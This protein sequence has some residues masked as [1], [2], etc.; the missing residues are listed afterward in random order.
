[1]SMDWE[2]IAKVVFITIVLSFAI[3]ILINNKAVQYAEKF[4]ESQPD[5]K[6]TT[7]SAKTEEK[8]KDMSLRIKDTYL[9]LFNMPPTKE[10][11]NFYIQFFKGKTNVTD[12]QL[13]ETI[14][15]S[16]PTL[17]KTIYVGNV[18]SDKDIVNGTADEVAL[19]FNEILERNPSPEELQFYSKM[20]KKDP[21]QIEKMKVLLM[22]SKEYEILQ[23]MQSNK[24]N[25]LTLRGVSDR[26]VEFIVKTIYGNVARSSDDVDDETLQ[27]LK[28]KFVELDMDQAVFARFVKSIVS[29]KAAKPND[30]NTT[31]SVAVSGNGTQA[32]VKDKTTTNQSCTQSNSTTR[33]N[34]R[35]TNCLEKEA[36][37]TVPGSNDKPITCAMVKAIQ[38]KAT[39]QF[40]KNY[41]TSLSST[42]YQRNRDELKQICDRN[43]RFSKFHDEDMVY[44]PEQEWSIPTKHPP[45]CI[46]GDSSFNPLMTQSSLI[47]TLLSDVKTTSVS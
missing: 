43:K 28:K 34:G 9:Y 29:F 27:F 42:I 32:S 35:I 41:E 30:T 19:I 22:Q 44:L 10:E 16:A 40:P 7:T 47:G 2:L 36:F 23:N 26:Q 37:S 25:A 46:K 18:V 17:Q 24:T 5:K 13:T 1:M 8:P 38:D 15:T 6:A 4:T 12:N 20:L 21:K 31:K 14:A 3:Y 39:C 45:V 11:T 33:A